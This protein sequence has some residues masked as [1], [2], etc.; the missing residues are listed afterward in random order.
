[1]AIV[2]VVINVIAV[3]I[4]VVVDVDV[5]VVTTTTTT[6]LVGDVTVQR[7]TS[8]T[9]FRDSWNGYSDII[10]SKRTISLP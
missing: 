10:C 2:A 8:V 9:T 7:I 1:M 5:D 3:I 6:T 4:I